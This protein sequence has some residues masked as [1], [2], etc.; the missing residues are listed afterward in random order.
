[1][2]TNFYLHFTDTETKVESFV[3]GHAASEVS[4]PKFGYRSVGSKLYHCFP[5]RQ[6]SFRVSAT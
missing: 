1:M 3:Q 2:G 6:G 4:K 5:D